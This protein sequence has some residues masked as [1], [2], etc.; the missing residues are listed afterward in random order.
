MLINV[1]VMKKS[2]IAFFADNK[3]LFDIKKLFD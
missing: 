2:V 1:V 3:E